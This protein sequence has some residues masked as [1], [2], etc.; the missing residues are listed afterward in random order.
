MKKLIHYIRHGDPTENPWDW[1][2]K[3]IVPFYFGSALIGMAVL[4][5]F[6]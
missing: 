4:I 3:V 6:Y 5:Y 2:L 1:F